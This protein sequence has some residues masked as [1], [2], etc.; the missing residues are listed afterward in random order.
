MGILHFT[1]NYYLFDFIVY[2]KLGAAAP[3]H[4]QHII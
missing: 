1:G 2:I 4:L 3:K